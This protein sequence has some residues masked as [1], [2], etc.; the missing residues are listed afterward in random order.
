MK[1]GQLIEYMRNIFLEKSSIECGGETSSRP[2]SEKLI[3]TIYVDLDARIV[4]KYFS[5]FNVKQLYHM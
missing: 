2:F 5:N 1:F 4:A 3:L